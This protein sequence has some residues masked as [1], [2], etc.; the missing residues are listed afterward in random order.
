MG[1]TTHLQIYTS[2]GAAIQKKD[3]QTN[4]EDLV[5]DFYFSN[6]LPKLSP[7]KSEHASCTFEVVS[8]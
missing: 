4:K 2:Y 6:F 7:D 8:Q 1:C 5:E 3:F